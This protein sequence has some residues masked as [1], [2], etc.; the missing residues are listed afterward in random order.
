M[1][2]DWTTAGPVDTATAQVSAADVTALLARIEVGDLDH[3]L[4]APLAIAAAELAALVGTAWRPCTDDPPVATVRL[5]A[6]IAAR[7][8]EVGGPHTAHLHE[9]LL[10]TVAS[11]GDARQRFR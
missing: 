7:A 8:P 5:I 11:G 9:R 1:S 6:R 10:A 2:A 4:A 3:T